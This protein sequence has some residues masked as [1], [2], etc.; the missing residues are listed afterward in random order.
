M[1]YC[2]RGFQTGLVRAVPQTSSYAKE[3]THEGANMHD[4]NNSYCR[5]NSEYESEQGMD[6][7]SSVHTLMNCPSEILRNCPSEI[8][9][10]C[11]SEILRNCPS[12]ILR[13]CPSEILRNCSS[14]ILRNCLSQ[15]AMSKLN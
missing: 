6:R 5:Y 13:N 7:G 15:N 11:P 10:N 1:T 8:L 12:E 3:I 4:F 14:E 2:I 9:Q